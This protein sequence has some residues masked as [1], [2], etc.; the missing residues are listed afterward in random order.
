MRND[1][2]TKTHEA[3]AAPRKLDLADLW[4]GEDSGRDWWLENKRDDI[5]ITLTG[6][7]DDRKISFADLA[8][9]LDWKPSRVSRALS[10]RENLTINTVAEIVRAADYDFDLIVRPK[11][12]KRAF[13]P[14]EEDGL[15]CDLL[16]HLQVCQL[17]VAKSKAMYETA[18]QLTRRA[19][20]NLPREEIYATLAGDSDAAND[21]FH[22]ELFDCVAA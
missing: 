21:K 4:G 14:W 9:L 10:G 18:E 8:R 7:L 16:E 13:Q 3:A 2:A 20:R 22:D 17:L 19:F 12:A 1:K 15:R 6:M 5:A 11:S